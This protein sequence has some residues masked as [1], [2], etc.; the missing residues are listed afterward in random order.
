MDLGIWDGTGFRRLRFRGLVV[1]FRPEDS[2]QGFSPPKTGAVK[3]QLTPESLNPED[4]R[5]QQV[6][7]LGYIGLL[8]K[9]SIRYIDLL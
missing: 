6:G 4:V 3:P 5:K 8:Y 2:I 9:A 7:S 1:R